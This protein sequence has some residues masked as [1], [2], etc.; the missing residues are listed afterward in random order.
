MACPLLTL[1]SLPAHLACCSVA[2][3]SGGAQQ[4]QQLDFTLLLMPRRTRVAERILE[5][6]GLLGDVAIRCWGG[7]R[8]GWEC[9]L[10]G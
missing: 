3:R 8:L 10:E 5:E 1:R 9:F 2:A 4:Q 7:V 6:Q